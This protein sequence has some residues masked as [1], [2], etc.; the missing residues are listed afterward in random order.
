MQASWM[1][2]KLM[3][4]H[5]VAGADVGAEIQHVTVSTKSSAFK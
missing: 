3:S 2:T 1:L 5:Q 4:R